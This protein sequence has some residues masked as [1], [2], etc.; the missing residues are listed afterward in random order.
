MNHMEPDKQPATVFINNIY[1]GERKDFIFHLR[2]DSDEQFVLIGGQ[3]KSLNGIKHIANLAVPIVKL[4]VLTIP[5]EMAAELT[6]IRLANGISDMLEAQDLTAQG[7]QQLWDGIKDSDEG[8]LAPEVYLL[9]LG[10]DVAAMKGHIENPNEHRSSGLPYML[11]WLSCHKWQRATTK[12]TS[13]SSIAFRQH[14]YD[15][16]NL[17]SC[18]PTSAAPCASVYLT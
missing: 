6:R 10:K 4:G 7:L 14:A 17:V 11:S 12:G 3:Y 5:R 9:D 18:M 13:E 1:A 15:G 8:Y 16:T 2:I